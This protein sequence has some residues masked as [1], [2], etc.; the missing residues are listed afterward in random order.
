MTDLFILLGSIDGGGAERVAIDLARNFPETLSRKLVVIRNSDVKYPVEVP[1]TFLSKGGK[2]ILGKAISY[3][4]TVYRYIKLSKIYCPMISLSILPEDNLINLI[5]SQFT[6]VYPVISFHGMPSN[7][8]VSL[9]TKFFRWGSISL[10]KR[11]DA[12][13][14]AVSNSVKRELIEQYG[15]SEDKVQ[16]IYNPMDLASIVSLSRE[17]VDSSFFDQNISTIITVGRLTEVKGQWHLIRVFAEVRKSRPCRLVICG[18]GHLRHY[19]EDL[20][21]E[22]GIH[23]DVTFLGWCNNPY[24]YVAKAGV[25]VSSSLSESFGNVLVEA[26]AVGCPVVATNCSGGIGEILG[27][28]G[29]YGLIS[30]KLSGV[31]HPCSEKLDAGERS[32]LKN[33]ELVLEDAALRKKMSLAGKERAEY[34][35][36]E[37]QLAEYE[38]LVSGI[39]RGENYVSKSK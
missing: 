9:F 1:H 37:K 7:N 32:L 12:S 20:V 17:E 8:N 36:K 21:N 22:L 4:V 19:L 29:E 31:R 26:M 28:N 23:E 3:P 2:S 35:S 34:F 27:C 14:V 18:E 24:K 5:A 16:V 38:L 39:L 13:A 33:I 10:L 30:E 11:S 25:F 15:V 6:G